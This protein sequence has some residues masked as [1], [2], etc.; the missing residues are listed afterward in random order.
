MTVPLT[1]KTP[2]RRYSNVLRDVL[3]VFKVR[4]NITRTSFRR[5]SILLMDVTKLIYLFLLNVKSEHSNVPHVLSFELILQLLTFRLTIQI[6]TNT[7]QIMF[8]QD[9]QML[10]L[11]IIQEIPSR[12]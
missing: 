11:V 9:I 4:S 8:M 12:Y 10:I 5:S 7:I 6:V 1:K 2:Q 3:S